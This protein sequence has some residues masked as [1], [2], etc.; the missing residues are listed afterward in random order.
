MLWNYAH[1]L[2]DEFGGGHHSKVFEVIISHYYFTDDLFIEQ[3]MDD[4]KYI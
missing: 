3:L 4:F 1:D 2:R